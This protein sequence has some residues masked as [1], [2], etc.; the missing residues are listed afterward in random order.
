MGEI[1][2]GDMLGGYYNNLLEKQNI[3]TYG[4]GDGFEAEQGSETLWKNNWEDTE[5]KKQE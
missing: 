5:R 4:H 1:G 3:C 2:A